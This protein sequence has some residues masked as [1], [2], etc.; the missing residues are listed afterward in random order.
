MNNLGAL[1]EARVADVLESRRFK[2]LARNLRLG[3][4]EIDLVAYK[5]R[6]H[7][8]VEVKTVTKD[9][10][11]SAGLQMTQSKR[12]NFERASCKYAQK[13]NVSRYRLLFAEVCIDSDGKLTSLVVTKYS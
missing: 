7:Y 4:D 12:M 10:P 2:V 5:Q 1:G 3:K 13:Y 11:V 8:L 9:S 6:V